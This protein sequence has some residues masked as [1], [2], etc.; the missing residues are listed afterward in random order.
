MRD[1]TVGVAASCKREGDP[2]AILSAD[3]LITTRQQSR[4][5]HEHQHS[6]IKVVAQG[7]ESV[8]GCLVVAGDV[9]WGEELRKSINHQCQELRS[10]PD[11]RNIDAGLLAEIGAH[12]YREFVKDKINKQI[13]DHFGIQLEE[14]K[15][16]HR[17]KE[18]FIDNITTEI[19]NAEQTIQSN[20]NVLLAAVD[21][22]GSH[23]YEIRGGDKIPHNDMGCAAIGSGMQP[24]LTEFIESEYS[25]NCRFDEGL[26]TVANATM[27]ARQASGVGGNIDVMVVG[28]RYIETAHE[29]TIEELKS[30]YKKTSDV[31]DRVKE[32]LREYHTV[33][34]K[35][36]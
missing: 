25:R 6:K 20:L 16:Q 14:L 18:R 3:R 1:M 4:I 28:Q 35:T 22:S 34:W 7:V 11:P 9:T 17:F 12:C 32:N 21:E 26:A 30:R 31:Q 5:E 33:E 23:I 36:Q 19:S 24:A 29:D 8:N 27:R 13:L 10:S 15:A 2:V